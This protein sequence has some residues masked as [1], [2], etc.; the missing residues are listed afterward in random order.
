MGEYGR[1][2]LVH[3]AYRLLKDREGEQNDFL[4]PLSSAKYL[5]S[6]GQWAEP[7]LQMALDALVDSYDDARERDQTT[8]LREYF[9]EKRHQIS[10]FN[11]FEKVRDRRSR[12]AERSQKDL[13]QYLGF[14]A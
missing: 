3:L 7:V 12:E 13:D 10:I 6:L 1:Y 4:S 14:A 5:E 11:T 9:R 8:G 2:R